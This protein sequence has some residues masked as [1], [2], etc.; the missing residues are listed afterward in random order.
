M[1]TKLAE[2]IRLFRRKKAMTQEHL[3]EMLGVTVGA[4]HK[5]ETRLSTP[6]LSLILEMADIFETSV[7]VLVG[8]EIRDNR[9][10]TMLERL[11]E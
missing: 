8:Y 2:N 9:L 5:W 7:D 10:E 6:E 11:S 3:A 4:V 1:E